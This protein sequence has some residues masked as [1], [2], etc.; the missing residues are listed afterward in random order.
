MRRIPRFLVAVGSMARFIAPRELS[1]LQNA[2]PWAAVDP[3]K[4]KLLAHIDC[5]PAS[6]FTQSVRFGKEENS[7][8]L[9]SWRIVIAVRYSSRLKIESR[10]SLSRR[11]VAAHTAIR[12]QK[13]RRSR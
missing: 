13:Q 2:G 11:S 12:F 9:R 4:R 5:L 7:M 6:S 1:Y 8:S 10:A 3:V